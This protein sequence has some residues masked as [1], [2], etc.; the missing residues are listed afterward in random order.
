MIT[1]LTPRNLRRLRCEKS[2]TEHFVGL[3]TMFLANNPARKDTITDE[4][5]LLIELCNHHRNLL[6]Q[7]YRNGEHDGPEPLKEWLHEMATP[8]SADW[9]ELRLSLTP[10]IR[11]FGRLPR[12]KGTNLFSQMGEPAKPALDI[13]EYRPRLQLVSFQ[14][15]DSSPRMYSDEDDLFD[16]PPSSDAWQNTE[17]AFQTST[18]LPPIPY[19]QTAA[20]PA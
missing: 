5:Y 20:T 15:S 9:A 7:I 13:E 11:T 1:P 3:V 14:S 12:P 16:S 6:W 10:F 2:V 18:G 17:T 8:P 19:Q 4:L